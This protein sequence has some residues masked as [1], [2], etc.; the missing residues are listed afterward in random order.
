MYCFPPNTRPSQVSE[1]LHEAGLATFTPSRGH[2]MQSCEKSVRSLAWENYWGLPK[3]FCPN[4]PS[5]GHTKH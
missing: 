2:G 3:H 5:G 1:T 4:T